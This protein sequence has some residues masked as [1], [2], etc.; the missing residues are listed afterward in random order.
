[1]EEEAEAK[2]CLPRYRWEQLDSL[3]LLEPFI[4][5]LR[6][7]VSSEQCS[8]FY[9]LKMGFVSSSSLDPVYDHVV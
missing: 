9:G 1:M 4:P 2:P 6:A 3:F 5:G 8:R 7:H